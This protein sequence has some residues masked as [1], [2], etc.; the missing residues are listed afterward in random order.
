M[1]YDAVK[2]AHIILNFG[3]NKRMVQSFR[4]LIE[5]ENALHKM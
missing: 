5:I 4:A 2:D 1:F 3:D